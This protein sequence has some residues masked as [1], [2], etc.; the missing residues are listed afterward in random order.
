MRLL[1]AVFVSSEEFLSHFA[2]EPHSGGAL[3]YRTRATMVPDEDVLVEISFPGLPNRALCRAHV[4]TTE[5]KGA[6][7]AIDP[8]DASTREFLV[9]VAR[10]EITVTRKGP[11]RSHTRIPTAL[12]IGVAAQGGNTDGQLADVGAGGAFVR[13]ESA[14][15]L[16]TSV[17]LHIAPRDGVP[18]FVVDGQVAW[19]QADGPDAG[20]GVRFSPQSSGGRRLRAFLRRASESARVDLATPS[21]PTSPTNGAGAGQQSDAS[22]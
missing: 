7:L 4:A 11:Q 9:G 3:F 22:E 20:F 18:G 2:E 5:P 19:A 12:P 21:S 16:G 13:S 6:W 10:G 8:A 14:P 17:E 15:P 1:T